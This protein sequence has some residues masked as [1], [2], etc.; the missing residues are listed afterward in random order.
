MTG[1]NDVFSKASDKKEN[2]QQY[3]K[4]CTSKTCKLRVCVKCFAIQKLGCV[5]RIQIFE[6]WV[7]TKSLAVIIRPNMTTLETN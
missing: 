4:C 2:E 6:V 3:L 7:K 5:R 1:D